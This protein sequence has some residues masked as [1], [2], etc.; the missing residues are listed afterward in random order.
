MSEA[1]VLGVMEAA[2]YVDDLD[3]AEAFYGG[4]LGLERITRAD[5]RHVFFRCGQSVVLCFIAAA[6]EVVSEMTA[7]PVPPHGARGPGHMCFAATRAAQ[8]AWRERL[9]AVQTAQL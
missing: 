8:A 6:T 2:L 9:D 7:M 3:A 4:V 1:V 5:G